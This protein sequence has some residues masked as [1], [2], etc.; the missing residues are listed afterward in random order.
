MTAAS[1]C[2]SSKKKKE[3]D[4]GSNGSFMGNMN[5]I[6]TFLPALSSRHERRCQRGCLR[7]LCYGSLLSAQMNPSGPDLATIS[8]LQRPAQRHT[9]PLMKE[10]QISSRST[11]MLPPHIRQ[12]SV[13]QQEAITQIYVQKSKGSHLNLL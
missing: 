10:V 12:L 3:D 13:W 11:H 1:L 4:G 2:G 6:L 8:R 5:E 7:L 9:Q